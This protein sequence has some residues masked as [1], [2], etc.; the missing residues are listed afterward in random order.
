MEVVLTAVAVVIFCVTYILIA[1]RELGFLPIGRPAGALL[2]AVLMV[3][4]GVLTPE[5][6]FAAVDA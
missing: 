4:A 1:A 6:S 2:G 5:E 3:A